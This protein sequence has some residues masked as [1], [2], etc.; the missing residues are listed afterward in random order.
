[1]SD[2]A[3]LDLEAMLADCEKFTSWQR[4]HVENRWPDVEALA[5]HVRT[6]VAAVQVYRTLAQKLAVQLH[7]ALLAVDV[8][9]DADAAVGEGR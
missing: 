9:R 8:L 7:G 1:M 2:P 4:G 6:L 5:A 3:G